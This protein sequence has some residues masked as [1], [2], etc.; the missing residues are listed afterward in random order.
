MLAALHI[1]ASVMKLVYTSGTEK[2]PVPTALKPIQKTTGF[3][4]SLLQSFAASAPPTP[5]PPPVALPAD[6]STK[7]QLVDT[8]I[9]LSIFSADVDVRLPKKVGDE[10]LRATKKKPPSKVK[11]Q[12]IYVSLNLRLFYPPASEEVS[13]LERMPLMRVRSRTNSKSSLQGVSFKVFEPT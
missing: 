10:L 9:S 1:S 12:L 8:S 11:Y 4:S 2:P 7:L 5:Q 13:R 6:P 3:F